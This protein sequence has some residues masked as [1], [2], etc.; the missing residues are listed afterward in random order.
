MA[1]MM[2]PVRTSETSFY[3]NELYGAI[4]QKAVIYKCFTHEILNIP[5]DNPVTHW[6]LF[7]YKSLIFFFGG[8]GLK[9][10]CYLGLVVKLV[11]YFKTLFIN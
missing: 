9:G 11:I 3:F 5:R 10:F 1:V 6:L 7:V 4:S 2:R 8:G